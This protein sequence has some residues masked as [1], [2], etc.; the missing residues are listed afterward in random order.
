[1]EQFG[2]HRFDRDFMNGKTLHVRKK[3]G[4]TSYEMHWHN[5]YELIFYSGCFGKCVLNGTEYEID[6][7]AL[8]LMTPIDFH[9][10]I[11]EDKE[12]SFS[13]TISFTEQAIEKGL[14]ITKNLSAKYIAEPSAELIGDIR[15]LYEIFKSNS[16]YREQKLSHLLGLI[17]CGIAESETLTVRESD[18][19]SREVRQ[20]VTYMHDRFTSD[21]TLPKIADIVGV[22]PSHLSRIF[23]KEVGVT[24]K[25]YLT[26]LRIGYAKRLLADSAL[27]ILHV[28][29]EC[30]FNTP[31]QFVRAFKASTGISP[32]DYRKQK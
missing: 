11:T 4:H 9:E 7:N 12:G 24:F 23:H 2:I 15:R 5:Y 20:T 18:V 32:S 26:G 14:E 1:M 3:T 8:F 21:V 28:G 19:L 22:S 6:D 29:F 10:I 25:K 31:S 30:G 27:S 16:P 13:E 17:L